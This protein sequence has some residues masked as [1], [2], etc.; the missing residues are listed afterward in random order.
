MIVLLVFA[1]LAAL[2]GLG[3]LGYYTIQLRIALAR[4]DAE[5][6]GERTRYEQDSSNGMMNPLP[7]RASISLGGQVQG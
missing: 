5:L 4:L 3:Y 6:A 7:R 2:T 1:L